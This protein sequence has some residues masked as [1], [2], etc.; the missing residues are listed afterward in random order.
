MTA[1]IPIGELL[2][3]KTFR[4]FFTETPSMYPV[5]LTRDAWRVWVKTTPT[6]PWRRKDVR[7]YQSG[8]RH[9]LRGV[10]QGSLHDAVLQSRGVSYKPPTRRVRVMHRGQ[11]VMQVGRDG[12]AKP[13]IDTLVWCTPATLVQ[14]YGPHEWCFY[15]RRP[16]VFSYFAR[17]HNFVGTPLEAFYDNTVRRCCVCGITIDSIR[18]S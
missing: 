15:C 16:T 4:K 7:E 13:R 12:V 11:P 14:D 2:D 6:T 1:M 9:I 3:D 8:V 18:R 10:D 17:H 5:Q